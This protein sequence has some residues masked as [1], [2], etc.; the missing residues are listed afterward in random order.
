M[1]ETRFVY[2]TISLLTL[3]LLGGCCLSGGTTNQN[4][5]QP[6]TYY[7]PSSPPPPAESKTGET[8]TYTVSRGDT[9]AAISKQFYGSSVYWRY[10]AE[11]NN[12]SDPRSLRVG[13]ILEI[14]DKIGYPTSTKVRSD[15]SGVKT[16]KSRS[17]GKNTKQTQKKTPANK[18][19]PVP[20]PDS[21]KDNTVEPIENTSL[22]DLS[23]K[24]TP[25]KSSDVESTN[26]TVE[27]AEPTSVPQPSAFEGSVKTT[28]QTPL[29]SK[30]SALDADELLTIP[31]GTVLQYEKFARGYYKVI[32]ENQSGYIHRR[33]VTEIHDEK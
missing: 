19:T 32:F 4:G 2:F 12:I 26:N 28:K 18:P 24:E 25:V 29:L 5:Y 17:T 11:Y 23:D 9:L 30:P 21:S 7:T 27:E 22:F 8:E 15:N 6:N 10:I 3:L 33:Y 31:T 13:Q 20:L 14:P 1:K 16:H